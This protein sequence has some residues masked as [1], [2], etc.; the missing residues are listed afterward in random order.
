MQDKYKTKAS[1]TV[2]ELF[3]KLMELLLKLAEILSDAFTKN[4][5]NALR[6]GTS[7]THHGN[8]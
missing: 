8:R 5:S 3:A 2:Y 7:V 4:C 6:P 1:E